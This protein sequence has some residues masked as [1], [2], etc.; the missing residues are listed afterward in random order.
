MFQT[1]DRSETRATEWSWGLHAHSRQ[2]Q[3]TVAT[4]GTIAVDPYEH[5]FYELRDRGG[6][7]I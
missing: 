1:V 6:K 5:L 4:I 3:H 2:M 7:A